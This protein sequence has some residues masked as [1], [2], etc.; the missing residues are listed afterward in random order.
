MTVHNP[1]TR[2]VLAFTGTA[3]AVAGTTAFAPVGV[4]GAG[5]W[6][7]A[8]SVGALTVLWELGRARGVI[9]M[10]SRGRRVTLGSG[11]SR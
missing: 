1:F 7:L 11:T 5:G 4:V 3:A 2:G 9:H 10:P 6:T 8:Y